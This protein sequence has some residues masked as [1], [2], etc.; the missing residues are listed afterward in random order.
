[1][2]R[3]DVLKLILATPALNLLSQVAELQAPFEVSDKFAPSGWMGDG[4]EG[5]RYLDLNTVFRGRP[6]PQD[7]DGLTTRISYSAG[8][9]RWAGIYWQYPDSNWGDMPGRRVRGATKIS[10]W[11]AGDTG[12]EIAEF[13]AGG[14]KGKYSD[15]FEV[16]L[17]KISLSQQWKHYSIGLVNVDTASVIGAFCIVL[18]AD[19]LLPRTVVHLDGV[20]YE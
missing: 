18:V 6:R 2:K 8:P 3:R 20:R 4:K 1:V 11:A 17:G 5:T 13:K 7:T 9:Q 12:R 15:S 10:F 16:T 19:P 14:I